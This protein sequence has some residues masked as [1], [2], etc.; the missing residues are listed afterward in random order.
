[1]HQP[2]TIAVLGCGARGLTYAELAARQPD[3]FQIVAGADPVPERVE[4][5]RRLAAHPGFRAFPDA[6]SLLAAGRLADVAIIA[7]QDGGHFEPCRAALA[8]G[9]DVLLEKPIAPR[10]D[11]VLELA[12]LA[13]RVRR[14]VLICHVLRYTPFYRKVKAI[15][16]SGAVGELIS[17]QANEGVMPWHQ[18]HSFVRGHWS[19]KGKSSPMILAK[20]CH[21][22]DV[23]PWLV[24]RECVK[25]ASFGRLTFFRPERAPAG[26]PARC[27]DGCPVGE[28]CAF[29]A[30]RYTGD[31]RFPW[32]PQV[33]DRAEAATAG[34]ITDWLRTSPW[35]RCVYRCDNDVVD[36]QVLA[37]EF[38][39]G[40]TGTFTMTAFERG[41]H[42]EVY[43]TRGVLRGGEALKRLS[44]ADLLLEPHEGASTRFDLTVEEGGYEGHSGGD[45]GLVNALYHELTK[46]AGAALH[47][48]LAASVHSHVLAFAAEEARLTGQVVDVAEFA[49]RHAPAEGLSA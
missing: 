5:L 18:A 45:A 25:V 33:F 46:P 17:L 13:D 15:L 43:G 20:C 23:I 24:G 49:R 27:T 38:A 21:D 14:R 6:A 2:L 44:G 8:L 34:E 4:K 29:N 30:H 16:D 42:L 7:T 3:H 40:M 19:V 36:H 11:H 35:G 1:M 26:A 12:R 22:L 47:T 10:L 37:L 31:M 28:S 32:L 48:G 39:G 9:Y 41:R